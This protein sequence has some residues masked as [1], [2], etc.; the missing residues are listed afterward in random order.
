MGW[1]TGGGAYFNC[2]FHSANNF[3]TW[4]VLV[5]SEFRRGY[6]TPDKILRINDRRN[7]F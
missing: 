6:E 1:E 2:N 5:E 3:M 4:S 7:G